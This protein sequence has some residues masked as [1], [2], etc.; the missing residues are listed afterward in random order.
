MHQNEYDST[1]RLVLRDTAGTIISFYRFMQIVL[2]PNSHPWAPPDYWGGYAGH[3]GYDF[4]APAWSEV[5]S[6]CTGEVI[7]VRGPGDGDGTMGNAVCIAE[8][9]QPV[10]AQARTHRYMHFVQYPSVRL[11][12]IVEQGTLLG[13][14]GQTG[15]ADGNHLHY[16]I[17]INGP[18]GPKID[19]WDQFNHS[20]EPEGWTPQEITDA[21]GSPWGT[22]LSWDVIGETTGIDY[23]P[24]QPGGR[25]PKTFMTTKPVLDVIVADLNNLDAIG[26]IRPGGL[27]IK[28]G[29]MQRNS[30]SILYLNSFKQFL[31][32]YRDVIPLGFYLSTY[33]SASASETDAKRRFTAF[34]DAMDQEGVT[35]ELAELGV[36]LELTESSGATSD[37]KSNNFKQVSWFR[38]V[39][40]AEGYVTTGLFVSEQF[41]DNHLPVAK[42]A[43]IPLWIKVWLS[44]D[45][46]TTSQG[47]AE[48]S[49]WM[50]PDLYSALNQAILLWQDG[51]V[52]YPSGLIDHDWVVQ[53]IKNP[54]Y[55]DTDGSPLY[56]DSIG[57]PELM[58]ANRVYFE[59]TPGI[60]QG[61]TV[62]LRIGTNVEHGIISYTLDNTVPP[63]V[64]PAV[65]AQ[66][67]AVYEYLPSLHPH[68][69]L[70][71]RAWVYDEETKQPVAKGSACYTCKPVSIHQDEE[72]LLPAETSDRPR[73]VAAPIEVRTQE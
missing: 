24:G 50:R 1:G 19:A 64:T 60:I 65:S 59:P 14:V 35:P 40:A 68:D 16:D 48:L 38:E 4:G 67:L 25:V 71:V 21:S 6:T 45:G 51:V 3:K 12:D 62:R 55:T 49:T 61:P 73:L 39:F 28:V 30:D 44:T 37:S 20:S 8:T 58:A 57:I 47:A 10:G 54:G 42:C 9:G 41:I 36:W 15:Q 66:Q 46:T 31:S 34:L 56:P 33:I 70:F 22:N 52:S 69:N 5:R 23:G 18:W 13:Y 17:T 29:D 72:P 53:P 11:G 63:Y 2:G 26:N 27:I 7:D 32:R 43:E